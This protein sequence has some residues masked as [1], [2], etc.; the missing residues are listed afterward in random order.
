MDIHLV[1]SASKAPRPHA[2]TVE[3][4]LSFLAVN[5]IASINSQRQETDRYKRQ[6]FRGHSSSLKQKKK[7]GEQKR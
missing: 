4:C 5:F 6:I 3:E 7:K 1:H 2:T